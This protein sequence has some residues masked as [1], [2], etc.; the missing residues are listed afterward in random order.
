M[1]HAARRS[2]RPRV[3]IRQIAQ[4][5][6]I[7]IHNDF[8]Q[9]RRFIRPRS[10]IQIPP[11]NRYLVPL[12]DSRRVSRRNIRHPVCPQLHVWRRI[13]HHRGTVHRASPIVVHQPHRVPHFLPLHFPHPRPPPL[14]PST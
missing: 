8:V 14:L 9:R 13:V 5:A 6:S 12:P 4:P 3:L 10:K 11:R 2:R 7:S 1:R